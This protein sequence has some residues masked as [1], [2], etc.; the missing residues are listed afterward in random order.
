MKNYTIGLGLCETRTGNN[1]KTAK[2]LGIFKKVIIKRNKMKIL[3]NSHN[4]EEIH[5]LEY[6]DRMK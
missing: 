1:E 2:D 3:Q 4:E 6:Q 5:N